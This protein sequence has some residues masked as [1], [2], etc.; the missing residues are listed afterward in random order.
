MWENK[1]QTHEQ[2]VLV[3]GPVSWVPNQ[4]IGC[5]NMAVFLSGN[6]GQ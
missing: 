2:P 4:T 5:E 3:C 6:V 1:A